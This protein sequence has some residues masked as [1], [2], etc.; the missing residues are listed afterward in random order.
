MQALAR[1]RNMKPSQ[2]ERLAASKKAEVRRPRAS[3]SRVGAVD[4]AQRRRVFY[5]RYE[6]RP[7]GVRL[8]RKYGGAF[9]NCWVS[10]VGAHRAARYACAT[11]MT[12]GWR[13]L[14]REELRV[15]VRRDFL[16]NASGLRSYD[17]AKSGGHSYTFH[18]WARNQRGR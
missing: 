14:R 10:A 8:A 9:V 2:N 4:Q 5:L 17:H 6:V 13:V 11:I 12:E 18:Q 15:A 3:E 1:S 16:R 7:I